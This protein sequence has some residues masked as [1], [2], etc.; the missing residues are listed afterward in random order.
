MNIICMCFVQEPK[1]KYWLYLVKYLSISRPDIKPG[2]YIFSQNTDVILLVG[3]W[4]ARRQMLRVF[5]SVGRADSVLT[6]EGRSLLIIS[7]G[8]VMPVQV[9]PH[10]AQMIGGEPPFKKC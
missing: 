5:K 3:N 7:S 2:I 6:S 9:C 4:N 8:I 1:I 10:I